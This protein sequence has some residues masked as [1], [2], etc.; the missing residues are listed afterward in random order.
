VAKVNDF[1]NPNSM[2]T[3]GI[4]GS[5]TMMIANALWVNFGLEPKY[6]ALMLCLL[7]GSVVLAELKVPL[8]QKPVYY[9]INVLIIF[10]VSAGT[11]IVGMNANNTNI[12]TQTNQEEE[13]I[14]VSLGL[15]N[16]TG[17]F[18]NSA[19]AD[20]VSSKNMPS[21]IIQ[22]KIKL[23]S[24]KITTETAKSKTQSSKKLK[25]KSRKFFKSWF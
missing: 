7:L 9:I 10:S 12:A 15:P 11:N 3:P 2:L 24:S 20:E 13:Q 21:A 19:M 18:I 8:W 6:T 5:M 1:L 16:I 22:N 17:F 25:K 4:A 23:A 14:T